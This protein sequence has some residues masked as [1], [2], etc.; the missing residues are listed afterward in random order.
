MGFL[1]EGLIRDRQRIDPNVLAFPEAL[2]F[3]VFGRLIWQLHQRILNSL[4][5]FQRSRNEQI[6]VGRRALIAVRRER[7]SADEGAVCLRVACGPVNVAPR[8]NGWPNARVGVQLP[9]LDPRTAIAWKWASP[10]RWR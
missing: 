4:T 6:N 7:I 9:V 2:G 8:G 1:L 10:M 5:G 3:E